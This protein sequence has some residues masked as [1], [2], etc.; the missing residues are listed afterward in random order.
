MI[1]Q[2]NIHYGVCFG[3]IFSSLFFQ[4]SGQPGQIDFRLI[5]AD[6]EIAI[7]FF[8][9]ITYLFFDWAHSLLLGAQSRINPPPHV[10]MIYSVG[11]WAVGFSCVVVLG[12]IHNNRNP[13]T[14]AVVRAPALLVINKCV[15]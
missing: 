13:V 5:H 10:I 4:P 1:G 8:L 2:L 14:W 12:N 9:M 15:S 7:A 11:I 6:T 3:F